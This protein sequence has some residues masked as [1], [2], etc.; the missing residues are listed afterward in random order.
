MSKTLVLGLAL[1]LVLVSG[2]FFSAQADCG[3]LPHTSLPSLSSWFSCCSSGTRDKD[4]GEYNPFPE[5]V[6]SIGVAG[7]CGGEMTTDNK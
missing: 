1:S 6:H 4:V 7:C 5:K 3:C 2:A